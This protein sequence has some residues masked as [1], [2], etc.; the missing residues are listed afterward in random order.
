MKTIMIFA[1]LALTGMMSVYGQQNVFAFFEYDIR[2][3]KEDAF[4]NGY[5]RDLEWQRAQGDDWSWIGWFVQNGSRR[6]RFVDAT[7]DHTWADF[8][9]WKV[10]GA[11]NSQYN[12]IHWLPY[13]KNPSGSYKEILAMYSNYKADWYKSKYLQVYYLHTNG[14]DDGKNIMAYLAQ[15]KPQLSKRLGGLSFIWM[16]TV[17]GGNPATYLLFI[18]LNRTEDLKLCD[19]IF[20]ISE[21]GNPERKYEGLIKNI[22][23]ELWVYSAELS[24]FPHAGE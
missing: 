4:I 12:R 20:R 2:T 3:D 8:D 7:P 1:G 10:D 13:V 17:S 5:T 18:A 24:L 14:T 23:S 11:E 22:E 19:G 21:S 9:D 6:G 16:K 15:V